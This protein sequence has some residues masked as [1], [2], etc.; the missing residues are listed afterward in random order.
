MNLRSMLER[1]GNGVYLLPAAAFILLAF[2]L[3]V[4][5]LLSLSIRGESTPFSAYLELFETSVYVRVILN[6]FKVALGSAIGSAVLGYVLAYWI[7]TLRSPK[8]RIAILAAV[9]LSFW[10]SILVRTY[11]WIVI[12]GNNGILNR[13]LLEWEV[14]EAPLP[15]LYNEFGVLV[16]TVSLLLPIVVL[17]VYVAMVAVDKRLMQAALSLG[18]SQLVVFWKIFFPL[19][20]PALLAS[21]MLVFIL[22]LGFLVT[23]AILGGNSVPMI[24]TV[25]DAT[26]NVLSNWNLAAA[27]SSVLLVVTLVVYSV[28]RHQAALGARGGK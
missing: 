11:S 1:A 24:A 26:I 20:A 8:I 22:T 7:F 21:S 9:G 2:N 14:I 27:L 23:P 19:T 3:P 15:L 13:L 17:T 4:L 28:Y 18:A 16:G 6:T 5:Q 10:I 25:L 12:L